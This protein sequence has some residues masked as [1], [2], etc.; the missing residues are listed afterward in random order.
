MTTSKCSRDMSY[1]LTFSTI[2]NIPSAI[3]PP[4]PDTLH[5]SGVFATPSNTRRVTDAWLCSASL[6]CITDLHRGAT[7]SRS[8]E[9]TGMKYSAHGTHWWAYLLI[10][11]LLYSISLSSLI[12]ARQLI[13]LQ[14]Q[15]STYDTD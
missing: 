1:I 2:G 15:Y 7:D 10:V 9:S 13:A 14:Q 12:A 6:R 5:T 3:S 8:P 11:Y 4:W